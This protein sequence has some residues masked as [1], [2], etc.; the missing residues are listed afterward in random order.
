MQLI[1]FRHGIAEDL[2][3]GGS[4]ATRALTPEGMRKT[5][6]AAEGLAA[7][8]DAPGAILTSP[9]VRALQT[10]AILGRVFKVEPRE[11]PVLADGTV[12]EVVATLATRDEATLVV[13]GHEPTLSRV[14]AR[15]STG[16]AGSDFVTLKKAGAVRLTVTRGDGDS[17]RA[18][19]DALLPPKVLRRLA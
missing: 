11:E 4:D 8:I 6:A 10:A 1:L 5:Q 13:V 12:D 7:L 9:K 14:A 3:E 19:L 18:T 16:R 2:V 15:L 17:P